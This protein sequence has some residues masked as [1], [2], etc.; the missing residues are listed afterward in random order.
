MSKIHILN[1]NNNQSYT[2]AI[3][4]ATPAGNNSVGY[5]WK[6][7]GLNCD[8]IGSTI[9]EVGIEPGDITQIEYDSIIAGDTIE[10]I[11][12]ISPGIDPT[13]AA[14]ESLCDI[15]ISM[16]NADMARIL[17]YYGHKIEGT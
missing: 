16:S 7:C 1:S 17:K 4:F 6:A 13:N 10:I 15:L 5:S 8:L 14:V 11:E 2:V 12:T 3:H 9:L